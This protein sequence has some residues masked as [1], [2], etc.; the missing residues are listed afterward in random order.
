MKFTRPIFE[1]I[2]ERTS[3][4]SYAKTPVEVETLRKIEGFLGG[5]PKGPFG[6]DLRFLL[7]V[8]GGED[9]ETL[10]KLGTYGM[11]R[12]NFGFVVGAVRDTGKGLE[13]Y[14]HAM[15]AVVLYLTDLGLG[16]CWL[17]GTF[18]KSGFAARIGA[19]EGETVPAVLAF[20]LRTAR[21]GAIDAVVR[22][23]AGSRKRLPFESLFFS[24]DFSRPLSE[25]RP[26]P[27]IKSLEM[28][29]L[30][31]SASNKQPWRMVASPDGREFHL[32]L[33]RTP[34]Y[35]EKNLKF[36]GMAD[37]QRLDM[38]IAMRHFELA[39]AEQDIHGEWVICPPGFDFGKREY[40]VTWKAL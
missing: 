36:F 21:R 13:D 8:T 18:N 33:E 28:V 5:L 10:K 40:V 9:A 4:R 17:G 20:G 35:G 19:K 37:M 23:G 1:L 29:R 3:W 32:F 15:E 34:G 38:G 26:E 25:N 14:G 11:I 27:W 39:Q 31:P 16:T 22:L 6:S 12:N 24:P 2:P 30:G 7:S